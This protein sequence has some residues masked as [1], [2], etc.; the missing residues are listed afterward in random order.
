[1]FCWPLYPTLNSQQKQRFSC[2]LFPFESQYRSI[3]LSLNV[4]LQYF[5]FLQH[6]MSFEILLV[7]GVI[8][9]VIY[10]CLPIKIYTDME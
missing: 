8:V 10:F 7:F 4:T 6:K 3:L 5:L 9:I 2:S 1:M